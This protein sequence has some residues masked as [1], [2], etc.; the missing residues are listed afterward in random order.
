MHL[1]ASAALSRTFFFFSRRRG[2]LTNTSTHLTCI[3]RLALADRGVNIVVAAKSTVETPGL[4]GTVYSVAEEVEKRGVK[5]L[6][7]GVD[8]R[9]HDR[10]QDMIDTASRELGAVTICINNASALWWKSIEE[11]PMERYD[12]I[13]QI[14]ARGTFSVT[15]A[16]LPYMREEGWGH[17]VTQSPPI[18]LNKMAG[19]TAYN[20]SKFGMTLTALGVAQEYPGMIAGNSIWPTTLIESAAT[21]N[22]SLGEPKHWRKADILVDVC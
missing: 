7:F 19:M 8:V 15:R 2:T 17:V 20:M 3:Y 13:N 12:L 5:A 9:D 4:A 14:N 22:H 1:A 16:C 11:T 6:P 21:V 10:V 18:V